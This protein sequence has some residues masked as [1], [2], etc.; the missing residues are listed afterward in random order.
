MLQSSGLPLDAT[1]HRATLYPA[2]LTVT[3]PGEMSLTLHA[4]IWY[5]MNQF[6]S[7]RDLSVSYTWVSTASVLA[8]VWFC[9]I[10]LRHSDTSAAE[11]KLR[12][13]CEP[14]ERSI[15]QRQ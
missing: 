4:G 1:K 10:V 6:Y 8:Q 7:D 9:S 13:A 3:S 12:C 5:H 2:M 14:P 15:N 11:Y